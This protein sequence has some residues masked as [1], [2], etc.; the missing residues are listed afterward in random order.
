LAGDPGKIVTSGTESYR[1]FIDRR[2]V[3]FYAPVVEFTY[4]VH[5]LEYH[6]RQITLGVQIS[7]SQ[8]CAEKVAVR[9]PRSSD[10]EVHYD[11]DNPTNAALENPRSAGWPVLVVAL[12]CFAIAVYTSGILDD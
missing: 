8:A 1:K 12:A 6:S 9:Y 5:G 2:S 11:P 7:G 3:T 4:R 10:V